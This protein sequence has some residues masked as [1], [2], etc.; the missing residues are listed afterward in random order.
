MLVSSHTPLKGEL[1]VFPSPSH[2]ND[3][4][5]GARYT[6]TWRSCTQP[7]NALSFWHEVKKRWMFFLLNQLA[8]FKGQRCLTSEP[9]DSYVTDHTLHTL[10]LLQLWDSLKAAGWWQYGQ[11][12][13]PEDFSGSTSAWSGSLFAFNMFP[14]FQLIH[15]AVSNLSNNFWMLLT[16]FAHVK[17]TSSLGS[18]TCCNK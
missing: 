15:T 1:W 17:S 12:G 18:L 13:N 6:T 2:P 5:L 9:T 8:C 10:V 14:G 16:V 7:W 4:L 3:V 11:R